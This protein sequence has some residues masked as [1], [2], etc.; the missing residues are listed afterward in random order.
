MSEG[1]GS[2]QRGWRLPYI[3]PTKN[4]MAWLGFLVCPPLRRH[5]N[6]VRGEHDAGRT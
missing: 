5:W 2:S 4:P 1:S 6:R 3:R